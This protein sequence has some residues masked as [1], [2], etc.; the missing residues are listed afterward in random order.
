LATLRSTSVWKT[1]R[2]ARRRGV[3]QRKPSS[4]LRL[5]SA[6]STRSGSPLLTAVASAVLPT[7]APRPATSCAETS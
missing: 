1:V 7:V 6:S 4:L 5:V 2:S 3:R